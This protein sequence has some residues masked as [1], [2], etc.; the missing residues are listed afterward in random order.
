[1]IFCASLAKEPQDYERGYES[2]LGHWRLRGRTWARQRHSMMPFLFQQWQSA[3]LFCL[4]A[5]GAQVRVRGFK[6]YWS[7]TRALID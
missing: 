4:S 3:S 1:M 7:R 2:S 5:C 6:L